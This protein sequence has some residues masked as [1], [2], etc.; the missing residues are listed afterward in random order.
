MRHQTGQMDDRRV[1]LIKSLATN[2]RFYA[3]VTPESGIRNADVVEEIPDDL[4]LGI[5]YPCLEDGLN[6]FAV[7]R[8]AFETLNLFPEDDE[9]CHE[10]WGIINDA[11]GALLRRLIELIDRLLVR[12]AFFLGTNLNEFKAYSL[13][14]VQRG[15]RR[16]NLDS[17]MKVNVFAS[18]A[19][20]E[21]YPDGQEPPYAY[22]FRYDHD[23]KRLAELSALDY[24]TALFSDVADSVLDDENF[25]SKYAFD[26]NVFQKFIALLFVNYGATDPVFYGTNRADYGVSCDKDM[27][28]TPLYI[29]VAHELRCLE[30]TMG[31]PTSYAGKDAAKAA[32]G[33]ATAENWTE[34][35]TGP[36]LAQLPDSRAIEGTL[37]ELIGSIC[38]TAHQLDQRENPDTTESARA[39]LSAALRLIEALKQLHL[40]S[41]TAAPPAVAAAVPCAGNSSTPAPQ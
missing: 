24:M 26:K 22:E 39:I 2:N 13:D 28:A 33:A 32:V 23:L 3:L 29:A 7:I 34:R 1:A 11:R 35:V 16:R 8:T 20:A 38:T 41:P 12:K 15:H 14:L 19:T 36:A 6:D 10:L 21:G 31:A 4:L 37:M 40:V 17:M 27:D 9:L 5:A 25:Q 18:V 30:A